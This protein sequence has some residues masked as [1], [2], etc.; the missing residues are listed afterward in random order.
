MEC[1]GRDKG[2]GKS[3]EGQSPE[4]ARLTFTHTLFHTEL[5][6]SMDDTEILY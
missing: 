1:L 4:V 5:P 6:Q 2:V 3:S